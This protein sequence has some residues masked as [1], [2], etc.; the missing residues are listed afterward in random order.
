MAILIGG[1]ESG[2][3][4]GSFSLL[5][6]NDT[7][8]AGTPGHGEQTFVNVANGNLLIQQRD[9]WL[10]SAG[11]DF[12]L[13][14]TYNSRGQ[15]DDIHEDNAAGWTWSTGIRL[16]RISD[17]TNPT[18]PKLIEVE[19]GD[20]SIFI[21]KYD[22]TRGLYV[23][24][25]GAGSFETIKDLNATRDGVPAFVVT[26][27]N[28]T[29]LTFDRQGN[30][31]SSVDT[32]GVRIDYEYQ[33]GRLTRV[34]DDAGHVIT[35]TYD[36][37]GQLTK[38]TDE[39]GAV[40]VQ[41]NYFCGRLCEVIDR[42]GHSTKYH[43]DLRGLIDYIELPA[44]DKN[45]GITQ[46]FA[47]RRIS[48]EYQEI[49]WPGADGTFLT[50]N[51]SYV[52][53]K[54]TDAEGGATTFN[55]QFNFG[56]TAVD[57][58]NPHTYAAH[59]ANPTA[60]FFT[61]G[62]TTVVDALGNNRAY[63][64]AD[65]YRAWRRA[66]GYYDLYS[67]SLEAT[68]PSFRAQVAAIRTAH[69]LTYG[70]D[71]DG[72]LTQ[73]IDAQ[74]YQ[75]TYT[76][77][78]QDNLTAITDRN[79]H[80]AIASD[81]AYYRALRAE[82]GYLD[83]SGL[84]KLVADLTADEKTAILAR[85]TTRLT[86]DERGNLLTR[87]DHE[88]HVTTYTWTVFNKLATETSANGFTT[89]YT[90][91]AKQNLVEVT[92][93]NGDLTRYEYDA[94][95][96]R[97]K[98]IV[99]LDATNLIDPAQQQVTNYYYDALG[100]NVRTMDAEGNATQAQYDH[101]GNLTRF[102]DGLGSVTTYTYDADNRLRTVTD[103]EG[104]TTAYL[105]DAV[106]NR[107]G[108]RDAAGHTVTY[109]YNKNNLLIATIDPGTVAANTRTTTYSYDVV[110]N[111]TSVT[112]AE[113]RTTTYVYDTRRA[114]VEV[115]SAQ[116]ADA[117]GVQTRYHSTFA[118]DGEGN[119]IRQTDNRGGVTEWLYNP[120]GLVCQLTDAAGQI[121]RYTYDANHNQVMVVAGFQL[122][123]ARRQILRFDYDAEDHLVAQTDAEG[124][125]TRFAYDAPG[126]RVRTIDGN[127][128][129]TDFVYD[130][131]N[132][133]IQEIRPE[134]VDPAT[135]QGVRYSVTHQFDANGNE[136]ATTDENGHTTRV[137][138]DRDNRQ[139]MV[140]DAT[141]VK[142]V[143]TYDS[144]HN[145]TS[146]QIGVTAH[147][148][149]NRHVVIDG[150]QNAQ[151]TTYGYD[152][153]NQLV[154]VTD[155]MGN[156][157]T[158]SDDPLYRALRKELGYVDW[159]GQGK[160]VAQLSAYDKQSLRDLYTERY[161]YDRVGNRTSLRD[162]LGR[163]TGFTYDALNRLTQTKDALNQVS[164]FRYDGNGN[165]VAQ[166]DALGRTTTFAYDLRNRLTDATDALGRLT[167]RDYDSFGNL[168]AETKAFGTV[169]ARTTY[170]V[171]DLNNRVTGILDPEWNSQSFV[172][173]AVGNR[174][175]VTDGR[176]N[177]T[178]YVYDALN[179]NIRI[180]DP[181][182]FETRFEY[183]GV[184]NRLALI[185]ANGGV[186]R[187]TYDAANRRIETTDA[188]GRVT[189]FDY[190]VRSNVIRQTTAF[191]TPNAETTS[192]EYDATNHL[193]KVIDAK[194]GVTTNQY[195][196]VYNR[197]S[198]TDARGNKTSYAFD[199]LN[200]TLTVTDALGG[201]TRFAYD[202]VGNRLTQTD[203][204]GRVTSFAYD[205]VNQ[206]LTQTAADG[207]ETRFA[208]DLAGNRASVTEAANTA[209]AATTSFYYDHNNR[210]TLQV[211]AL[212]NSTHYQYDPN[213]NRTAV[214]D[215]N[216][217]TT[218]YLYD[219]NNRVGM[220]VDAL[221]NFTFY[222]YDGNGN[223]TVVVDANGHTS[224]TYYN[225]NNEVA[226][227]VDAEGYATGYTYDANGNV[228]T[229]TLYA[230]AL[231]LPL[232]P[233]QQPVPAASTKDQVV[234]FEYDA[235]NRVSA[236][237]DGE[238]FRTE[239][240][241]DA[242]GNRTATKLFLDRAGTQSATTRSWFDALNRETVTVTAEGYLRKYCYDAVGNRLSQTLYENRVTL[243]SNGS[244]PTPVPGD[245]GRT[246]S[247]VYDKLNRVTR[248]TNPLNVAIAWE[249]DARGNRTTEIEAAG[250][251]FER[252]T[253]Y[254]Y[255]L[256]NRLTDTIDAMGTVTHLE[257]DA[258][259]NLTTR[260]D[261]YG[262]AAARV[263]H[264]TYDAV[265]RLTTE[266]D[267][268]GAVTTHAYDAA[269]NQ[270]L[271]AK[272]DATVTHTETYEYD[273][274][275]LLSASVN[276]E[277]D[278]T[279]YAYDAAGNR[280]RVTEAPGL[281]EERSNTFE[282][283]R[284]N[285]QIAA[286]DGSGVRAEYIYDGAGN[287]IETI[288]AVG[289]PEERHSYYAYDLDNRLT[290]ITDP[291]GGVTRYDYDVLGNQTR[292]TDTN[293]GVQLNTFDKLGRVLTS[294]SAGGVLT[295][296]EYDLRG[297]TI[298]TSQSWANGTDKRTTTYTYDLLN[299]KTSVT[300]PE[301]FTTSIAY[302]VFGNQTEIVHGQYL[303][304]PGQVGFDPFKV[305]RAFVQK[306][307]FTYD[308]ADRM[309]SMTDAVGTIT[310]YGYDA[311]GNR[312]STTEAA[313]SARPR[314]TTYAYDNVNRLIETR[315]PEGGVVRLSYDGVG[316]QVAEDALQS[317]PEI[318]GVWIHRSFQ[319]DRN[320]RRSA[321][322]DPYG[323][324]NRTQY[325]ALGNVIAQ[326]SAEGTADAR[327]VRMEYDFNNRKT[328][329]IDGEG[330]RTSYA[331]DAMGNR[332]KV[333]DAEGHV[334]RY[335]FDGGNQ[336]I[337]VLD[338]ESYVTTFKYDSAGNKLET[339]VW[340]TRYTGAVSDTQAPTPV[341]SS[342]DRITRVVY[343][344][345]NRET[346]LVESDGTKTLKKY[347]AAGNLLEETLYANVA[348]TRKRTYRYDLNNRLTEFTDIDGTVTRFTYDAS[349][350][351]TSES[352]YS[353][354]DPNH[355]RTTNYEYDLNNRNT[356]QVFDPTGLNIVQLMAYDRLGNTV[357]LTDGNGHT[358]TFGYDLNNRQVRETNAL[359]QSTTYGYDRVGNRTAVTDGN[360][361]TTN[362]VYDGNNRIT[363]EIAPSVT[364]YTIGA[365]EQTRRPTITHVYD[366]A[367]NEVQT[368]D[369]E[370]HR[371]T[372]YF[373]G[374]QR[375]IAE[376]DGEG[377]LRRFTVNAAG[378]ALTETLYMT[379]LDGAAHNPDVLPEAPAGEA[380][381]TNREY[382][383][384]GRLTRVVYPEA[385]LTV[386][387]GTDTNNPTASTVTK[388]V[389]ERI[390]YDAYGNKIEIIDK[391]GRR[392]L[393]WFDVKNRQVAAVDSAGYLIEFSFDQQ[394]HVTEQRVYTSPLD[395]S[396]LTPAMRPVP[397]AGEVY[398][399][400]KRYDAA[401]RVTEELAPQI[402]TF[403]PVSKTTALV[404][405]KTLY[406]YD[407][408]GNALTK[409][410]AAGTG[411]AITE[412]S[413][414]DAANRKIAV[415][416]AGRVL[417]RYEY[418][419]NGN[420]TYQVRYFDTVETSVNLGTLTGDSNFAA[421]VSAD[422]AHDEARTLGYDARNLLARETD[423]M[424]PGSADDLTK[425]YTYD[426]TG[427]RTRV[428][429][430][431][432]YVSR[433]SYDGMGR[434]RQVISADGS[435]MLS[436][437]DA[438]GN[439]VRV[440]S[441]VM[442]G[443]LTG[444]SNIGATLGSM[445]NIGWQVS[446]Q[447]LRSWV[448]YDTV[449]HA[450]VFGYA[451]QTI[452]QTN[453]LGNALTT[454]LP[455]V[456][457]DN[458]FFRVVTQD[459]AGNLSWTAEQTLAL[460]PRLM[461]LGVNEQGAGTLAVHVNLSIGA[462]NPVLHYGS[463]S[464]VAF[465][466]QSDGSYLALLSGV[467]DPK[468]LNYHVSWQ[469]SAGSTYQTTSQ[470]FQSSATVAA[471][472]TGV[473]TGSD[474]NGYLINL[475]TK[476]ADADAARFS[477]IEAKWRLVG[478]EGGYT[479]MAQEG[480]SAN[481]V[482]TYTLALGS[483]TAG[484]AGGTYEIVLT[485]S[486]ES[487][488]VT[489][490][491]FVYETG[492]NASARTFDS[493]AWLTTP[494]SGSAFVLGGGAL[495]GSPDTTNIVANLG[496]VAANTALE[497]L[498]TNA[499]SQ[500]HTLSIASSA[501]GGAFDIGVNLQ[502]ALAELTNIAG[503]VSLAWRAA[504]SSG[505][506]SGPVTMTSNGLGGYSATLAGMNAGEYELRLS[507]LDH[508][509][510]EVIVNWGNLVNTA[511]SS[512]T[513]N[514]ASQTVLAREIQGSVARA[515]N[516][517][518]QSI[519]GALLGNWN[520]GSLQNSVG[521]TP[522]STGTGGGLATNG[523]EAGYYT[524]F[525][526]NALNLCIASNQDDG[527]WRE[528]G[529]DANGNLL[530]TR[531]HGSDRSNPDVLTSY[532][533]YDARNRKTAQW[534][535]PVTL[536]NGETR[537][538]TRMSYNVLDK[539]TA[540]TD[541]SGATYKAQYNA[542]GTLVSETNAQGQV[543]KLGLDIFG[544]TTTETSFG[545]I[546]TYKFYD[547]LGRLIEER[548]GL[549]LSQR[550]QYDVFNR[551]TTLTDQLG[552]Q[553]HYTYDQRD[554]LT[555][556]TTPLGGTDRY[557]Y[558]GRNN[559]TTTIDADGH[560]TTQV[561]DGL[562]RVKETY[563]G[564]ATSAYRIYD[565]YGNLIS[566][567]DGVGRVKQH[568]YGAF[569]RLLEDIDE[570]GHRIL[571]T[572]DNFGRV[573][574]ETSPETGK[575]IDH[576][577]D[578]AGRLLTTVDHATGT[579]TVYTYDI[580]GR[581]LTEIVTTPGNA[582]D[583]A[584]TY[585]YDSLGQMTRWADSVT[586][587]HLNYAYDA[588]GN[589]V[590][591]YTDL[592]YDPLNENTAAN[593][594]F[595]Y[596]D[597]LYRFDANRRI[598]SEVQQKTDPNGIVT[599]EIVATFEY[600]AVGNRVTWNNKGI[601]V[602]YLYDADRR[603]AEGTWTEDGKAH[604]QAWTY[605][606]NGN[607]RSYRTY[608]DGEEKTYDIYN[609]DSNN[610]ISTTSSKDKDGNTQTLTRSY[611]ASGRLTRITI[612]QDKATITFAYN[613][614][615]DGREKTVTAYGDAKGTSYYAYDA[616][617]NCIRVDMGK[618]KDQVRNEWKT[619]VYDNE[620]HILRFTHDD[621]KK[622]HVIEEYTY[623]YANGAPVG[624]AGQD[625][626]NKKAVKL[627]TGRYG[628]VIEY[629]EDIPATVETSYTVR[630][631]DTL[632]GIASAYYGN[633]NL[634]FVIA[635][636]N[637]LD[638]T[639]PLKAGTHLV[640][641]NNI[642]QGAVTTD[643]HK[644]YFD[645][646]IIGSTLPNLKSSGKKNGCQTII[647]IIIA[648]VIA[649]VVTVLTA[650]LGS[651]I[652]ASM[653]SAFGVT[654]GSGTL[655]AFVVTAASYAIA[656]AVVAAA[657]SIVQQGLY[658]ALGYQDKFSWSDVGIAAV[659]GAISGAAQGVGAAAKAAAE[660]G[661]LTAKAMQYAKI[662]AAALKVTESAT[663]Q[664]L[665]SGKIT[666][667]T[668]LA[669]AGIGGYLSV[670]NAVG[671]V[672]K[673]KLTSELKQ[674]ISAG[675]SITKTLKFVAD[676]VTPWVQVAE[677][678]AREGKVKPEDW[679]TAVG[680]TLS[681]AVENNYKFEATKLGDIPISA[682]FQKAAAKLATQSLVGG[683]LW[684]FDKEAGRSYLYNSIGQE[685]GDY[686]GESI[687]DSLKG[688]LDSMK[689]DENKQ[690]QQDGKSKNPWKTQVEETP[691][692]IVKVQYNGT[693]DAATN[694]EIPPLPERKP[695]DLSAPLDE[696]LPF[697]EEWK[698]LDAQLKDLANLD[699]EIQD[700]A[701]KY[702]TLN[703][704]WHAKSAPANSELPNDEEWRVLD[705]QL[706]ELA[707][708]NEEI[709]AFAKANLTLNES[710]HS[711]TSA[712]PADLSQRYLS[713]L[714]S[715]LMF[716]GRPIAEVDLMQS[717]DFLSGDTKVA[718]W[719][720]Y[721]PTIEG[722]ITRAEW[723]DAENAK[724]IESGLLRENGVDLEGK[725][726]R[727]WGS[728]G[729]WDYKEMEM[730][731]PYMRT[732]VTFHHSSSPLTPAEVEEVQRKKMSEIA[733]NYMI[734]P[735]GKLYEGRSLNYLGA[736][737]GGMNPSNV[738]IVFLGDYSN[739]PLPDAA[740]ATASK[741]LVDLRGSGY[742]VGDA[743]IVTHHELKPGSWYS[744]VPYLDSDSRPTELVGAQDQINKIREDYKKLGPSPFDLGITHPPKWWYK[745]KSGK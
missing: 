435:G 1:H 72:Y 271:I 380:R 287:K 676:Y 189:H 310:R 308:A 160:L 611:D 45:D 549:G 707:K 268:L 254:H 178:R 360:G 406:T 372:H 309:L 687:G 171:Y 338:P 510:R 198:T 71:A 157:L 635:D 743:E 9:T 434:V 521:L 490:G 401:G 416:D 641:P 447:G 325:D 6:R 173:D 105:Y 533:T 509:G 342:A 412:Y 134:V 583:R 323:T 150:T 729:P 485:G 344:L 581:R 168:T 699:A 639:E 449:S 212:G 705:S 64:N 548:D 482:T 721:G 264:F 491:S 738:G 365:G 94:S 554:R 702:L 507:Y 340:F 225:H 273:R 668:S 704:S 239:Y 112:D 403:D 259:G 445:L 324:V 356:R 314:T 247:Y 280:V 726:D 16:T 609:Y 139:V 393:A 337:A 504:G 472:T 302:D 74:G 265:N 371:I 70:Y 185:D 321:E 34:R 311:F 111:R 427:Q 214:I 331:Y 52:V 456:S 326:I 223:R 552:Y 12:A 561:F 249:Y 303:L 220:I 566:E 92:S 652:A 73:V 740:V 78:A 683:A 505:A 487:G 369:A 631:G 40:L 238:G 495:I 428:I 648:V 341:A 144:R 235:L 359:G 370:G 210:L 109:V 261:A 67:A 680:S 84:G 283:D 148:D 387:N 118:Y 196:R 728:R 589:R 715:K 579:S 15:H 578:D 688:W 463:G 576:S 571:Y 125:T 694:A 29:Q 538:V 722:L 563:G 633:P 419:G 382:D 479:S 698:T 574:Q 647:M 706:R 545:G 294:L 666:S 440:Y 460:P 703:Q 595:R 658:M 102:I 735:D 679:A 242:V 50:C 199:A 714:V 632:Q 217:N 289:L 544:N 475:A 546:T 711:K 655:A 53:S 138:F 68:K 227:A 14:R 677:T 613:Y 610:R 638:P 230:S 193:R 481:G 65:E 474:T 97:T 363:Q 672:D 615:G 514:A 121:T 444:A 33:S 347:D 30:L 572:Y 18:G 113:G 512:A 103:A 216:G 390:K 623:V 43:Y 51:K 48:F 233:A 281:P 532:A 306:N 27:A 130:K 246:T 69:S 695:Q 76:Y 339:R 355:V 486:T 156:A 536:A 443:Q 421:L 693:Y 123:E 466:A 737:V 489:L 343:D 410:L 252:R 266:T 550:Y 172:Y 24:T 692:S 248:E 527:L 35:Y 313:N 304:K 451:L 642:E 556:L 188:E 145:R 317:D 670:G 167:H 161:T 519:A 436:E 484:L 164:T 284:D 267:P 669:T 117:N 496:N 582:N 645:S 664:L 66:N 58:R 351:K 457:G 730:E 104:Y 131:N 377:A 334:A 141:G 565:A 110:G 511:T 5:N 592:G 720:Q 531:L 215:A 431:D 378:D 174:L 399:T 700:L 590:R 7:T 184:G 649:V 367:G 32:N 147:I 301:S 183:D 292:I 234:H 31:L 488:P 602:H 541:A 91:D 276:G 622:D 19:Y 526:Y 430:E 712:S 191:G 200:R 719:Y 621:G 274:R 38:L 612:K 415:I 674:A 733:Y 21:Y 562:N 575:N 219:A 316:N 558:D 152:E 236:R 286:I 616:N 158:T 455:A 568:V 426:G 295:V 375:L 107:I 28:Q 4:D 389:E 205:A 523:L 10:P 681:K 742:I 279:E 96:N 492:A 175:Q 691:P 520:T 528:Y 407:D 413:Y 596:V 151:V 381:T 673:S 555:S 277:G 739:K 143:Y 349:N 671:E 270:I 364:L 11:E 570:D 384:A 468:T 357:A 567:I 116:V 79:G 122:P 469:D 379:R 709:Q 41:Y 256:T 453:T 470:T 257:L 237:L 54:I 423:L 362:F 727:L 701:N 476:L 530:E 498:Y 300:D 135:G 213:G 619:M 516:G 614:W 318:G 299:R 659:T 513:V 56:K 586:G 499:A 646:D 395:V 93:A 80:A 606:P 446:G 675:E 222:G 524:E 85:Y 397:P 517:V 637:G 402:E 625:N 374:N 187:L 348:G 126:N 305:Q 170:Y 493:L 657:G 634:W 332:T 587:M 244:A 166:T 132:R 467:T 376:L 392:S 194:G 398:V 684:L 409:T 55:Y 713:P 229:Q 315:T 686:L 448:V 22:A 358:K 333:T 149:A 115:V 605:D 525:E 441:G 163:T 335:Y 350:N 75:T 628:P 573:L 42:N 129:A 425:T 716:D 98:R 593:P 442:D 725:T 297:N 77:D 208:Y 8:G 394:D 108:V 404:R 607:V 601:L 534:D 471:V 17:P 551:R 182:N 312:V 190:D 598:V 291:M 744:R 106:G 288:Q 226:L 127:G 569:A 497:V 535:I 464:T 180:L 685:V 231:S 452:S 137:F 543:H 319:Y 690:R 114:L 99:Y 417:S 124:N 465:T 618:D 696:N 60:N 83:A 366:A 211:D 559:R 553:A 251:A 731:Y 203:A 275:N 494:A 368:I 361:H 591:A 232:D 3:L 179:R 320:G 209:Q 146:V 547:I 678:Y 745:Y 437:Y 732:V 154:A 336:L 600:D 462:T 537:P 502:L 260:H 201:V 697:D 667:W 176:G 90:Y 202:A 81:A 588:E 424:G 557:G 477:V 518:I 717:G 661:N 165:C 37:S 411:Q 522:V 36:W 240:T 405:P 473:T 662:A 353:V 654:L 577:Y 506:F 429:D 418:D 100:N 640:I 20:G 422:T 433:T 63:S 101:F 454:Q 307:T 396:K 177:S 62:T 44:I 89:T 352:I 207:I 322:I 119:R 391:M 723:S 258:V 627:D 624:E 25:D 61:G 620:G 329:D 500:S 23:S 155:G 228:V 529:V 282:F 296:N 39:T 450:D 169:E 218:T 47:A 2:L 82:L 414:Y 278:R 483:L 650:G 49:A 197:T 245:T 599:E 373:D 224:T 580:L 142:T 459:I 133:L 585:Q 644:A 181:L 560:V 120:D 327:T 480:V 87:T 461:S 564:G 420:V 539:V 13:V 438:A 293:G 88:G 584:Y 515:A 626:E 386:L 439:Q 501:N 630:D 540:Q 388:R 478:S 660:A 689:E 643:T 330:N 298:R 46:T 272:G 243:P 400:S 262:T 734:A 708:L 354:T 542:M 290:R 285:R 346:T 432:G 195:D 383:L 508:L 653:A 26:R 651:V 221:N 255:D 629:G 57:A 608:V 604:R 241:Y 162:H 656:G 269:G 665:T 253:R 128:N 59:D 597:H 250:T 603:V 724:R 408:A 594:N 345:T 663:K 159:T 736:H 718:P 86:Y 385:T 153:F 682:A 206:L 710:W 140:E 503:N 95:G 136:I 617:D 741:L 328:A 192:Y 204:L 458:L 186:T 636:A 263:T